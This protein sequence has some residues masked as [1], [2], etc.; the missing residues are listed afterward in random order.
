[1]VVGVAVE[2]YWEGAT[3]LG[4]AVGLAVT[5]HKSERV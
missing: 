1:M 2:G 4:D 3:L 5:L